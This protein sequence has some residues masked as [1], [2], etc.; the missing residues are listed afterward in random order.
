[1]SRLDD[2]EKRTIYRR[3]AKEQYDSLITLSTGGKG[4]LRLLDEGAIVYA[5]GSL[6]CYIEKGTLQKYVD[7][8]P[9][10]FKGYINLGHMSF[11]TFPFYLGEWTKKDL[12]LEDIGDGRKAL[13]VTPHFYQDSVFVKELKRRDYTIGISAEFYYEGEYKAIPVDAEGH[14]GYVLCINGVNID[15]F[16]VVGECGNVNSSGIH[17]QGGEDLGKL[18]EL[19]K[20]LIEEEA[21]EEIIEE[22][23]IVEDE[24]IDEEETED[25]AEEETAEEESEEGDMKEVL[26]TISN[27]QAESESLKAEN[28]ELKAESE[29]LKAENEKLSV[30]VAEMES[31]INDFVKDF[32][33]L[34]V[35]LNPNLGAKKET[36]E[37]PTSRY[38]GNDGIGEL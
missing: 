33:E 20:T 14:T 18:K 10:D 30:K 8:L 24:T 38:K 5:D 1:M 21:E 36:V 37:E 9:D 3:L 11:A 12:S 25:T 28:A 22:E 16:G 15:E 17:L 26:D 13:Y 35:S 4:R 34:T 6:D 2:R 31:E 29:S 27:L 19:F 7:E 23:E 32:K